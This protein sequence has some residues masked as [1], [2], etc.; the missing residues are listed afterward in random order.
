M[1]FSQC[2]PRMTRQALR[3]AAIA[4]PVALIVGACSR[5]P[6]PQPTTA[7]A[8]APAAA[9]SVPAP[10]HVHGAH[11]HGPDAHA[12]GHVASAGHDTQPLGDAV[13]GLRVARRVGCTGCHGRDGRG[14]ELWSKKGAYIVRSANLTEHVPHYDDAG[15]VALLRQGRTHS[16]RPPFGMPIFMLQRLSDREIADVTAWL[17]GL[18]PVANPSLK[19]TWMSPAIAR[20]VA[21]GTYPEDDYLPDKGVEVLAVPPTE[22]LALGRHIAYT[23]CTECHGRDLN[24]WGGDEPPSLIV[25]KGYTPEGFRTLMRTGRRPDGT[26]TT[27]GMM[28]GVARERFSPLRDDEI[29]ALKAYLDSR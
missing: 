27:T 4:L 12:H 22:P 11:A 17:R 26:E 19:Q 9:A 29:A 28:S 18:P 24:G 25:A 16:G 7:A 6:S 14:N 23:S 5:P 8:A 1:R 10:A 21:D 13:E 2:F 3:A 15:L 20:Q